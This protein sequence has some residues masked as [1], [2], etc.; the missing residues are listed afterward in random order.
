MIHY[1][2]D[3]KSAR[4]IEMTSFIGG[5]EISPQAKTSGFRGGKPD[6]KPQGRERSAARNIHI[7]INNVA[8]ALG[9]AAKLFK[10]GLFDKH[11]PKNE[12]IFFSHQQLR[13]DAVAQIS[14]LFGCQRFV[15]L[16]PSQRPCAVAAVIYHSA[17]GI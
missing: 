7:V 5:M 11:G 15:H 9:D 14:D 8:A 12:E 1:R 16:I 10:I 3:G 2:N 17:T 13:D 6:V 4:S